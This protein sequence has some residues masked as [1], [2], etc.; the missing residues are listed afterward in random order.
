M[1]LREEDPVCGRVLVECIYLL[2]CENCNFCVLV[3]SVSRIVDVLPQVMSQP[4]SVMAQHCVAL[5]HT[6]S[7]HVIPLSSPPDM[8]LGMQMQLYRHLYE[9]VGF[10]CCAVGTLPNLS[11]CL[12]RYIR[13]VGEVL[14]SSDSVL[15]DLGL[16]IRS[17]ALLRSRL[18]R[19]K[20]L[21]R[22][23]HRGRQQQVGRWRSAPS[24]SMVFPRKRSFDSSSGELV[25][26]RVRFQ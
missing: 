2:S 1:S 17:E 22:L 21:V 12:V 8:S 7:S 24:A 5:S 25:S 9:A 19:Q 13:N 4:T 18:R 23:R 15:E 20:R 16:P 10:S 6:P 11:R 14:K 3:S 26:K